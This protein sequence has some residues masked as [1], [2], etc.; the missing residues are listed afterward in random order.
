VTDHKTA[1]TQ[2]Q[3]HVSI[4][5]SL[6]AE[7]KAIIERLRSH[8]QPTRDAHRLLATLEETLQLMREHLAHEQAAA[9]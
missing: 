1:L 2:A 7:Q 8:G 4:A 3:R 5:E 9:R 6:V